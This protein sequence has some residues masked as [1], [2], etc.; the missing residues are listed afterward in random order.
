MRKTNASNVGIITKI[1]VNKSSSGGNNLSLS[2]NKEGKKFNQLGIDYSFED[3][4]FNNTK[5]HNIPP[6]TQHKTLNLSKNRD[7]LPQ[8]HYF[9]LTTLQ[10]DDKNC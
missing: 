6:Y 9:Y 3:S 5:F 4:L 8:K 1:S 10:S 7:H 2:N